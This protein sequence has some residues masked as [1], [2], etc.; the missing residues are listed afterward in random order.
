MA[1][2]DWY[3]APTWT[4]AACDTFEQQLRRARPHKRPQYLRIQAVTLPQSGDSHDRQAAGGLLHRL[5]DQYPGHLRCRSLTSCSGRRTGST[6]I[7]PWPSITFAAAS[8][9]CRP[10]GAGRRD[11]RTFP[12]ELLVE[13]GD[14]ARLGEAAALLDAAG[15]PARLV[16]HAQVFRYYLVRARLAD[17]VGD[18]R[19]R[20]Y[21]QRA[22]E[23]AAIKTPQLPR[24]PNVGLVHTSAA[25]LA[26]LWQIAKA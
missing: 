1:E 9:P 25:V 6:A 13:R 24:H 11:W 7:L 16:F 18:P 17:R 21:A 15:L 14:P 22:L 8:R 3:R 20:Q 5:L 19:R 4:A 26:E 10:V 2:P 23:V 12:S